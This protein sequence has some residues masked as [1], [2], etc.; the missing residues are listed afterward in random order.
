MVVWED[1]PAIA[2]RSAQMRAIVQLCRTGFKARYAGY[3]L[4]E[5]VIDSDS[6]AILSASTTAGSLLAE[7]SILEFK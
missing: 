6:V 4:H 2:A 1:L 7:V 3:Y 5:F